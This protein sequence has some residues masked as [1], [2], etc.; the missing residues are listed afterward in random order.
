V[1]NANICSQSAKHKYYI[2]SFGCYKNKVDSQVLR[3]LISEKYLYV[4]SPEAADIIVINTCTFIEKATSESIESILS[5]IEYKNKKVIVVGCLGQRYGEELMEQIPELDA[6][7]GTYPFE[8]INHIIDR[9]INDEKI[10]SI[11][12]PPGFEYDIYS[13]RI[14]SPPVHYSYLKISDGCNR[15][16]SFC[17]IP[18]LKGKLRSRRFESII[19][20]AECLVKQGVKEV[21]L[22]SQDSTAY[23]TDLYGE[24]KLG[25]LLERLSKIKRLKWLRLLYNYPGDVDNKLLDLIITNKKLCNYLDI[26]IQHISGDILRRMKRDRAGDKLRERLLEIREYYPQICLRTTVMVG[27]PG[28]TR[29][30]FQE[31]CNFVEEIKFERLGVFSYSREEGT[32]S[33]DMEGQIPRRV[34]EERRRRIMEIQA[35]ISLKKN[36]ALI[37]KIL[38][39]IIDEKMEGKYIFDGR[40]VWDAPEIDNGVLITEGEAIVGDIV[41]V[42]VLDATEYD[43]IGEIVNKRERGK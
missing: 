20:E 31:L 25:Y 23:G 12:E 14:I 42:K 37:G 34:K 10:V 32:D 9:V 27:F 24:N 29:R 22:I 17:I 43:L 30:N 4:D 1:K 38:P 21:I 40:T 7:M 19:D 2:E 5:Y 15:K 13:R 8:S 18:K 36:R 3:S 11:R 39:V 33:F 28:E 6:V 41:N 26:P 35:D 16:C